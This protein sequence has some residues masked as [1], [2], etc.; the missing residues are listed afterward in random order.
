MKEH[1]I[2]EN[3]RLRAVVYA[4]GGDVAIEVDG[5]TVIGFSAGELQAI[6][7]AHAQHIKPTASL[8]FCSVC[9]QQLILTVDDCWHPWDVEKPCAAS[10]YGRPGREH[11][12]L[13]AQPRGEQWQVRVRASEEW[14]AA[15]DEEQA[16][17][18]LRDRSEM[19][20]EARTRD[21]GPWRSVAT[22]EMDGAAVSEGER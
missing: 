6:A 13:L 16:M 19:F 8:G 11:F 17:R 12:I 7:T 5:E 4:E 22:P 18:F 14:R 2:L 10:P 1:V 15:L 3:E 20:V 9:G 21:V